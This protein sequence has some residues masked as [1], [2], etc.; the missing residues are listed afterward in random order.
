MPA[1][2]ISVEVTI[3]G[4]AGGAG[5]GANGGDGY[6]G[7]G[8]DGSS[9]SMTLTVASGA[10]HVGDSIEAETGC[11]GI[12]G[13]AASTP[14]EGGSGW[15]DGGHGGLGTDNEL[16]IAGAGCLTFTEPLGL[17]GGGG[18]SSG[19]EDASTGTVLAIAGGGGGGGESLCSGSYGGAGG[20][21]GASIGG[22][23]YANGASGDDGAGAGPN[24]SGGSGGSGSTGVSSYGGD[25][26]DGFISNTSG[27]DGDYAGGGG[28]GG[29]ASG[30]AGGG[31]GNLCGTGGGGGG[32][33]SWIDASAS[34]ASFSSENSGNGSL[35]VTFEL[36]EAPRASISSPA[37]G[38]T[39]SEGQVVPTSFS[40][41]EG[42]D[43]P[44]LST[45]RDSNGATS[46][47][48][49]D[50]VTSS[51]GG[52]FEYTVTATS[53]DGLTDVSSITYY[54]TLTQ[55]VTYDLGG[56]TGTIPTQSSEPIGGTFVVALDS[57]FSR[58]GYTFVG[59]NDGTSATDYLSP[60]TYTMGSVPVTLTA[61][62][63]QNPTDTVAFDAEGGGSV[64]SILGLDGTSV[65]LPTATYPG[66]TFDGWFYAASGGSALTSPYELV[67]SLTLYAQWTPHATDTV[68]FDADGGGAVASILGLDGTS[69]ELPTATY[70]GYTFDGW[71][72][73]A[74]GGSA[75]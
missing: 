51:S 73:A 43:G 20:S 41:T 24:G 21:A 64:A 34:D 29:G 55:P 8:A 7:A 10:I 9:V 13:D 63:T 65:E 46:T 15:Q 18:G 28:A 62:W 68:A 53:A 57:A 75:L 4:G 37:G 23:N 54:V 39:Y 26:Y 6:G 72:Y 67:G 50:L 31:Y 74:S 47:A 27:I 16:C 56:G 35:T 66:Y 61:Q 38:L 69:V 12:A 33:A 42:T 32:G 71:F 30:G 70:P 17:A 19:L 2:T 3:A 45:C 59:W 60:D 49:G 14:S 40:C 22:S 48:G 1:G 36:A 44:G 11:A 58:P 25:G 5:G 52:P